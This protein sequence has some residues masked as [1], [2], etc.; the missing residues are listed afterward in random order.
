MSAARN[1]LDAETPRFVLKALGRRTLGVS[2][3]LLRSYLRQEGFPVVQLYRRSN[4]WQDAIE[5]TIVASDPTLRTDAVLYEVMARVEN[6]L[7]QNYPKLAPLLS[8]NGWVALWRDQNSFEISITNQYREQT[9]ALESPAS[10]LHQIA[11]NTVMA[12]HADFRQVADDVWLL[13]AG[14]FQAEARVKQSAQG[15]QW[16][17]AIFTVT[18]GPYRRTPQASWNN[19]TD[20]Q[21]AMVMTNVFGVAEAVD[22]RSLLRKLYDPSDPVV[23]A[24]VKMGFQEVP[25]GPEKRHR[26]ELRRG[27]RTYDL[28]WYWDAAP[29]GGRER[30]WD[31]DVWEDNPGGGKELV[32]NHNSIGDGLIARLLGSGYGLLPESRKLIEQETESPRGF[33]NR[34]RRERLYFGQRFER[35]P[36]GARWG[37][38][39]HVRRL[40]DDGEPEVFVQPSASSRPVPLDLQASLEVAQLSPTGF[41][42]GYGGSGPHQLALALLLDVTSDPQRAYHAHHAFTASVIA[43]LPRKEWTLTSRRILS[44]LSAWENTGVKEAVSPRELLVPRAAHAVGHWLASLKFHKVGDAWQRFWHGHAQMDVEPQGQDKWKV[45]VWRLPSPTAFGLRLRRKLRA[46][47][48]VP[49]GAVPQVVQKWVKELSVEQDPELAEAAETPRSVLK[50]LPKFDEDTEVT[51]RWLRHVVGQHIVRQVDI[52]SERPDFQH[53]DARLYVIIEVSQGYQRQPLLRRYWVDFASRGV[54]AQAL[55]QWAN[56][57]GA[58]LRVDGQDAGKVAYRNPVLAKLAA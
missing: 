1:I 26:F 4:K 27:N 30:R 19:L 38:N 32:G 10:V 40:S 22:P 49:L 56:L 13:D 18:H 55:R 12:K 28:W 50:A 21:F 15:R 44:W 54:L 34:L 8:V 3:K 17:L 23:S 24:L 11:T 2:T 52:V 31:F 35:V 5:M 53:T 9:E 25:G 20:R 43:H 37:M 14:N 46:T 41:E 39:A 45:T 7:E 36:F 16:D 58:K 51:L 29:G 57:Q 48:T 42:W 33:L 6:W 47:S